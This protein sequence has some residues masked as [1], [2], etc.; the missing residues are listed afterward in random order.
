M[1]ERHEVQLF[2][3]KSNQPVLNLKSS[4]M[5]DP[6]EINIQLSAEN[7]LKYVS[8]AGF[9]LEAA[10]RHLQLDVTDFKILDVV[11][12][13]GGFTD[14]VLQNGAKFVV[15]VDVAQDEL[16]EKIKNSE[17]N[18]T[19][20]GVNARELR[21]HVTN[22]GPLQLE[23]FDLVM[24]DV[25]FISVEKVW[26]EI[27]YFLKAG[28]RLLS[29][30]KPQ[31]EFDKKSLDK[32]GVVKDKTLFIELEKRL[33]KAATNLG[34]SGIKYFPSELPGRDGNQEFFLYA[35]K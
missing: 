32:R 29:L 19:L 20:I 24:V 11:Q 8:R 26:P 33:K 28:G 34:L 17:K 3:S 25:S 12:S 23:S 22:V 10:L 13:T 1:I 30:V 21:Q 31:F 15:G 6:N 27:Y 35:K 7:I 14:C 5:V 9:K 4:K 16:A 18:L 2:D